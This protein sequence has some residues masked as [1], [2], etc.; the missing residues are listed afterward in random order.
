MYGWCKVN[1]DLE[2]EI[3]T[4]IT[5]NT[6]WHYFTPHFDRKSTKMNNV[7]KGVSLKNSTWFWAH[8]LDTVL[9]WFNAVSL[10]LE[11]WPTCW[12]ALW[13]SNASREQ[14]LMVILSKMWENIVSIEDLQLFVTL[15]IAEN[16][17]ST[18]AVA[19]GRISVISP[20]IKVLWNR[21]SKS[22]PESCFPS[23]AQTFPR[24]GHVG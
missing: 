7:F 2:Y 10:S 3:W 8:C 23:Q 4:S 12:I 13:G 6:K 14:P 18:V 11:V 20:S 21:P 1:S 16:P 22:L 15:F 9:T 24:P 19:S 5:I 17:H